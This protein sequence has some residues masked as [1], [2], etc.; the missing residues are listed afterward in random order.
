M[1][2]WQSMSPGKTVMPETSTI[3]AS[4]G[5]SPAP[6]PVTLAIRLS[7]R[8]IVAA[9]TGLAPVPSIR[10][11]PFRTII[12]HPQCRMPGAPPGR[13]LVG[14]GGAQ[15]RGVVKALADDLERQRQPR[16]GKPGADRHRRRPGD[17]ERH[18]QARSL[19]RREL[20]DLVDQRR[21]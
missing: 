17:I 4:P 3:S 21:L 10:R 8:T 15:H 5:G 16:F 2:S 6:P 14:V 18:R 13:L 11:A 9:S 7:R 1:W 19:H 12:T 20:A